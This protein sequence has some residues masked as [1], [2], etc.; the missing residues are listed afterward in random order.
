MMILSIVATLVLIG[1]LFYH[2]VSLPLSSLI[3][4]AWT[5]A[6]GAVGLWSLWLL[7]PLAIILVPLN[8]TP[9]RKSL[10]SA[11]V[12][13]GFRKV[14]PPMSRTE[15]EAIDAG[16]TWWEG[17]LFRGNPDWQKLHNYPQPKLTAEE[18]AFLDGPVEEACRMA[19][20][21]QITHEM[22]DLPPELWAFL[23]E[24]RF[25]AMIIKKEYGGLE[26]S[27]YAQSRVLQKLAG[28]SGILAITVGVPNS[29]GPG[30][31]LQHYGTDAQ[32][33]HYLPRLA[34]GQEIP[35]FA[36]TSP[37]AGSDAGAIPD[38]GVV[39]MGEWQDE[40]VLGM[41]LTW[42][43]RYITLAPI[44]TVLG[45]A[46]KLSDPD[47]L[48]G[49]EQELGITCALIP[50]NTPGVEIGRRHFPLNVPFQNGPTRGKDIFVP[51]DYIIGGPKMA[52]QGW[53]MLVECLSV[54]RGITLPSNSTGSL[55]S[56]ALA[57]GAYAHIR[58]QFKVSIGKM[59][60]IEEPLARIAGNAY[61]MDAAASLI[62]YGIMLG[63]KPAVLSAI[64]KYHCTHRG[65]QSIIDAMDIAGGKGIMLG[66]GN[67][68]AR[69]YQGAPIAITV[70]G[71][72]IL[73][74]T[75]MIFGQ[76]AIRCH[77]YVLE[78]MAAAQNNDVNA[79]DKLLFRHIGHVGSN[80]VRSFWL[81]LTNGLTSR[82]PT[83]DATRRYYQHIN[84]LSASLALLSDVSMA[85]LGGSLK[86]RERISARLGDVLSQLYL[87]SAVLKRYDDEGRQEAD[88]PLVH[89]GVQDALHQAEQAI[90]DLLR[91]FPNGAV[92][93]LL[94]LA[95][96]PAGRRYDAPSD[97]LDHKLAKILQTP[98]ATRS[99]IGRGQYLTPSEH[100]P[101][102]LLEQALLEVM[103]ADPIHQRICKEMGKNLPFTRL[104]EL[105]KRALKE[106]RINEDEA[107]ILIRAEESRL[108]S[109]NVDDFE[110]DALATQPVKLP[111]T[112]RKVEAA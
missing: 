46:F 35:C 81:G 50:T 111:E 49:G 5:A 66:E 16:T 47:R 96:F 6:L 72:N 106:G 108:R 91:N 64:V 110:P 60:G 95:I 51:I 59:E 99:R 36:L 92:A 76:G 77:P 62:T 61:V 37:E 44:A 31:L 98:S 15:K 107:A 70:E 13:R 45:L 112:V 11:P 63:E 68:L 26:F 57:T 82:S 56:I 28:V 83:R 20:D 41:R 74:R 71:A 69:A 43:K 52:G 12:F 38:T 7:V 33:N 55:K 23:K 84:R 34:R 29:L 78:E 94:S 48:L 85:V 65:Q 102:G 105:A 8:V 17:D 25:F 1:A 39:C 89:W 18:Q 73:T 32:K 14:M 93:G 53:R 3:L 9:V 103:A 86:R 54:G 40:Q 79:F 22:A 97:K 4:L 75:M 104:D 58:R 101:V 21:F 100:N 19:N 80:L 67:F 10:I 24:H 42:N 2:R 109:I 30:E 88:L 27:A 90:S 87:A